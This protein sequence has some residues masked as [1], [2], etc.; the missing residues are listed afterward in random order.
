MYSCQ[1]SQLATILEDEATLAET[2]PK[3]DAIIVDGSAFVHS[4]QPRIAKTFGE[5]ATLEIVPK[6]KS[7]STKYQRTDFV[8]D[9]YKADSLKAETRTRRGYGARR[10]VMETGKVPQWQYK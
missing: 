10:R 2:E 1:K 3:I 6:I 9:V 8:F 7:Y 5:Y 4:M